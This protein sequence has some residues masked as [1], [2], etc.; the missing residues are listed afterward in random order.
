MKTS[1]FTTRRRG[2]MGNKPLGVEYMPD[3]TE[4]ARRLHAA[5]AIRELGKPSV[6]ADNRQ[7]KLP[8]F[9]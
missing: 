5:I 6:V 1:I 2:L 7:L 3:V 9:Y 8:G 4:R